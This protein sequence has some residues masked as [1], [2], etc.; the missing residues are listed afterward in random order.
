[1]MTEG[2]REMAV[3]REKMSAL[4]GRFRQ[5]AAADGKER[6][7]A[8]SGAEAEGSLGAVQAEQCVFQDL[9]TIVIESLHIGSTIGKDAKRQ[10]LDK[11]RAQQ[12]SI[13]DFF[14]EVSRLE[15]SIQDAL[16]DEASLAAADRF[17]AVTLIGGQFHAL[18]K[19]VLQNT[20]FIYEQVLERG[21]R[22]F[23]HVDEAGRIVYANAAFARMAR[24]GD[25][26]G[27]PLAD[28]FDAAHARWVTDALR[29]PEPVLR[30]IALRTGDGGRLM[31]GAEVG[32]LFVGREIQGGFATL[33][34]ISGPMDF[35]TR[36]F[37]R[38][39]LGILRVNLQE[40]F[41]YANP[42]LLHML[43]TDTVEGKRIRD[44]L[45]DDNYKIVQEQLLKRRKGESSE[46]R[47]KFRRL[48]DGKLVPI[49]LAAMPE[50]DLQNNVVGAVS[51]ARSMILEDASEKIQD[52][53]QNLRDARRLLAAVT[54]EIRGIL[55]FDLL[56]VAL[57]SE[58]RQH[59]RPL[60]LSSEGAAFESPRRW[61]PLTEV[62]GDWVDQNKKPFAGELDVYMAEE[63]WRPLREDP[64]IQQ[65][66]AAG[67]K[68]IAT[69][70]VVR[71]GHVVASV[72]AYSR[73]PFNADD[74]ALFKRLPVEHA[75]LT[76]LNC[77]EEKELRFRLELIAKVSQM[78]NNLDQVAKL[79]TE[80]LV[81]H[82]GWPSVSIFQVDQSHDQIRLIAQAASA[83]VFQ[84]PPNCSLSIREGV[85]GHV[86][87]HG[88]AANIPDVR[89]DPVFKDVF[90]R[91]VPGTV[92]ELCLPIVSDG[93]VRW[94]LNIEDSVQNAFAPEEERA[95]GTVLA[96][97]AGLLER[98]HQHHF[99][100]AVLASASDAIIVTDERDGIKGTNP[101]A[102]ALLGYSAQDLLN[103]PFR[104][105]FRD[106]ASARNILDTS[107]SR[108]DSVWL[109]PRS[110]EAREVL[111]SVS[112]LPGG[113]D[114]KVFTAKDLLPYKRAERLGLL[115]R[116]V[117]EV[118]SQ[119]KT[120]LSLVYS[121]LK[122][123]EE[124]SQDEKTADT[125]QKAR[126]QLRQVELTYDRLFLAEGTGRP[127][128]YHEV[129][130]DLQEVVDAVR[131]DLPV[132]DLASIDITRPARLSPVRGD[133]YQLWFCFMTIL[134]HLL[135]FLPQDGRISLSLTAQGEQ[136]IVEIRGRL[137]ELKPAGAAGSDH[138]VAL[139]ETM[140]QI[141]LG[142]EII[143]RFMAYHHGT[144][145][146]SR[147]DGG[148]VRFRLLL[149]AA[150]EA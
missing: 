112:P 7:R 92:S 1:M 58:G 108:T 2:S 83:P 93:L 44:I 115:E 124:Q 130:L 102:E 29:G 57:Y 106:E 97:L 33:V 51:F 119:N 120:P 45:D 94:L 109:Q 70:P 82:Y 38:S 133:L 53:I 14:T 111:L 39:L 28:F 84:L 131:Q 61:R 107:G 6:L 42:T 64:T 88:A 74:L 52:H 126:R 12:Y 21:G 60:F 116:V 10:F 11:V 103:Q 47:V 100:K 144:F 73:K 5:D 128:P 37:N 141:A 66:L 123:L 43:G 148:E 48:S 56:S 17:E 138:R 63:R 99:L 65:M 8:E 140:T 85:L 91:A 137:P 4:I 18:V 90:V 23:C 127:M 16:R 104:R 71:G 22:G 132:T 50:T 31:V 75:V 25:L 55:A 3:L 101:A 135:R 30:P 149:P 40:E 77:E 122:R 146:Q 26:V 80:D 121:W 145:E 35:Q 125:L 79:V 62:M 143:R 49:M 87:L 67:L 129:L 95:L 36:V 32:P 150:T 89:I 81:R 15:Q 20:S 78:S 139:A 76:A 19:E 46:Y 142:D 96:E 117:A 113:S 34:D 59:V 114:G 69:I 24:R 13:V 134:S 105:Y 72:T 9:L 118:A 54:E 110:G 98:S 86:Y 147:G 41:T 27:K 136:Q 68:F